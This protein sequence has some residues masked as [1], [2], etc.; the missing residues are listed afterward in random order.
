[1]VNRRVHLVAHV[2]RKRFISAFVAGAQPKHCSL[3]G[4]HALPGFRRVIA[5]KLSLCQFLSNSFKM[6]LIATNTAL[7][8]LYLFCVSFFFCLFQQIAEVCDLL[9]SCGLAR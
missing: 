7:Q 5:F 4:L 1:M 8:L 3:V 6:F 2:L 9:F